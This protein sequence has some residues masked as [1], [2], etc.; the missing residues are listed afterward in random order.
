MQ[1]DHKVTKG[2]MQFGDTQVEGLL[3]SSLHV[4]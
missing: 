2:W 3:D 4:D 1:E